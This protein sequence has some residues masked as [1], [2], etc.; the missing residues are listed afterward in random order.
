M[1]DVQG[2]GWYEQCNSNSSAICAGTLGGEWGMVSGRALSRVLTLPSL[3]IDLL[4]SPGFRT[5]GIWGIA[6]NE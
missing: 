1:L 6:R 5:G 2:S 3:A 4:Y